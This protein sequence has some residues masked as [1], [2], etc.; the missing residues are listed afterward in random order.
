MSDPV[1]KKV[2]I[3]GTSTVSVEEAIANGVSAVVKSGEG[4]ADWFEVQEVRGHITNGKPSQYQV[5]LKV[6]VHIA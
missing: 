5:V 2:E 3:I 1:Y 6:G 4:K